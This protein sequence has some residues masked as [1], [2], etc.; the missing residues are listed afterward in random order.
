MRP[1][2][3]IEGVGV[4]LAASLAGGAFHSALTTVFGSGMLRPVIAALALGYLL[5]LLARSR[6]HTGRL[7]VI[8]SWAVMAALLWLI[9]PP[10][11]PYI[12][13]H[14]GAL[15]L[16]RSLYFHAGLPAALADLALNACALAAA[17]WALAASGRLVLGLWSFFLVQA[18]FVG[19]PPDLL[20]RRAAGGD[21]DAANDS[22]RQA[23]RAAEAAVRRLSSTR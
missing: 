10:L 23:H 18:L 4:A 14:V 22:F 11:L 12:L 2:T 19:I 21:A 17:L 6:E 1:A 8:G 7:T 9:D 15:W 3:F 13:L 16:V 20:R 5:Y